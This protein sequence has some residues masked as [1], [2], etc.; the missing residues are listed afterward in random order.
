MK[1]SAAYAI[2]SAKFQALLQYRTAALA[3]MGT[4]IFWGFLRTMIFVAFFAGGISTDTMTLA[5]TCAYIWYSQAF[6]A[7]IPLRGDAELTQMI[8]SGNVCFEL[9]R[10][11][12][13]PSMW[14]ARSLAMRIAP[15]LLRCFPIL[16]LAAAC[17]QLPFV[18]ISRTAAGIVSIFLATTV[19]AGIGLLMTISQ[20]KTISGQG[21]Q[22][23]ASVAATLF[24]GMVIPLPFLPGWMQA[25]NYMLP[26]RCVC[27]LPFRILSG[28]IH[29]TQEIAFTIAI[30]LFWTIALILFARLCM[31]RSFKHIVIQGG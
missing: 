18:G 16:I 27:D 4:Q 5:Q 2:F 23:I 1:L 15:P 12:D 6:L 20:F 29:S 19:S 9:L 13:L 30:Q 28:H 21:I 22:T 10:P 7:I 11:V 3:G 17:G 31:K 25:I 8:R 26:F 24:S 14:Y